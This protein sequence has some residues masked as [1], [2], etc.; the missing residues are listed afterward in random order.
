MNCA[1]IQNNI[2]VEIRE[3][4]EEEISSLMLKYQ[5]IVDITD[6]MPVPHVD[7]VWTGNSFN[8]P[9]AD[10]NVATMTI[11]RLAFR[12]RFTAAEKT[13][14][15]TLAGTTQGVP[16]RIFLDDLLSSTFIDLTREDTTIGIDALV[17]I[18]ILTPARAVQ[19]LTTIPTVTEL[20]R[21]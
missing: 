6:T 3:L 18:G 20:Y 2:V 4:S 1:L 13:T 21:G 17:S 12:N 5:Q 15:Y 9:L 7:W 16:L 14:I 19:I 8:Q 11:T 10:T